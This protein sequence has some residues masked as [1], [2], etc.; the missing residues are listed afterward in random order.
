MG[1]DT[2]MLFIL[3]SL[4]ESYRYIDKYGIF[5]FNRKLSASHQVS[6]SNKM[7][8]KIFFLDIVFDFT[9]NNVKSKKFAMYQA[10]NIRNHK[11]FNSISKFNKNYLNLIIKKLL[12]SNYINKKDKEK[13]LSMFFK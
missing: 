8:G 3:F 11:L 7:F 4:A 6:N 13:L 2:S 9:K 10:I 1:E 5:R 12:A